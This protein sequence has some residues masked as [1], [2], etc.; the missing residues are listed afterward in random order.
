L[1]QVGTLI[2]A[3]RTSVTLE[4]LRRFEQAEGEV[5]DENVVIQNIKIDATLQD[6][7]RAISSMGSLSLT[8]HSRMK[9][10]KEYLGYDVPLLME[11]SM[12][13]TVTEQETEFDATAPGGLKIEKYGTCICVACKY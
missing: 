5:T 4:Y 11:A 7:E 3:G 13:V 9:V 6:I 10:L 1:G 8:G 12:L 2:D